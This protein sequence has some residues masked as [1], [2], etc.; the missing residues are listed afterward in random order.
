MNMGCLSVHLGRLNFFQQCLQ[1]S[2]N[3]FYTSFI[4]Y[5]S[6]YFTFCYCKYN[7]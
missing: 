5:I 3:K 6:K 7:V 4:K 1:L 2:E